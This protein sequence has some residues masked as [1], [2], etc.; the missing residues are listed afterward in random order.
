MDDARAVRLFDGAEAEIGNLV[1][2]SDPD[3]HKFGDRWWMF[4]GRLQTAN[5]VNL[6]TA[7]LPPGAPL[8]AAEWETRHHPTR[9]TGESSW[10]I[11]RSG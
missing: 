7:S 2:I 11:Q 6:F 10:K 3:V 9:K 8:G 4:L 1:A 5:K